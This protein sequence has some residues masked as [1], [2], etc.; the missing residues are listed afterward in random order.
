MMSSKYGE[1]PD[2]QFL[3]NTTSITY[4]FKPQEKSS[5]MEIIPTIMITIRNLR[6]TGRAQSHRTCRSDRVTG[7]RSLHWLYRAQTHSL[8]NMES[9][10][11][12]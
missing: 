10:F 1:V 3:L 6:S 5:S 8:S 9:S 12:Q 2:N 11:E 7:G 4:F